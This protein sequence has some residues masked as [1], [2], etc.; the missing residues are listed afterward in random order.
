MNCERIPTKL[1]TML[2]GCPTK[3]GS[4]WSVGSLN[5]AAHVSDVE[6]NRNLLDMMRPTTTINKHYVYI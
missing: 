5:F 6:V 1:A 3:Q 4:G 2:Q